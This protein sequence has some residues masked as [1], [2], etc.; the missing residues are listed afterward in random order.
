MHL[1]FVLTRR[2]AS[3]CRT[4]QRNISA[5]KTGMHQRD[6][7]PRLSPNSV[8]MDRLGLLEPSALDYFNKQAAKVSITTVLLLYYYCSTAQ[9]DYV[10]L[11][12][13]R[14]SSI[15]YTSC[16]QPALRQRL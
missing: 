15:M 4:C 7:G 2:L 9:R 11:Y 6:E 8:V 16:W 14:D 12:C 10:P 5:A 1:V 3:D 13:T